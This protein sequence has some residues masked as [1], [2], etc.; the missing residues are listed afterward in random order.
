MKI[1]TGVL[2]Q[3]AGEIIVEGKTIEKKEYNAKKA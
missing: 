2:E 1:L 3:T